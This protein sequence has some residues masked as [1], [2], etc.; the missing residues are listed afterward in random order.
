[1]AGKLLEKN[2]VVLRY[3]KHGFKRCRE[4]TWDQNEDYLYAKIDQCVGRDPEKGRAKGMK[5]FLDDKTLKPGL[6]SYKR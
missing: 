2:P 4:L 1:M 3:A 6:Q 5:Q